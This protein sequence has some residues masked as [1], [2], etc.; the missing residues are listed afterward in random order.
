MMRLSGV[1][2]SL[3]IKQ[4]DAPDIVVVLFVKNRNMVPRKIKGKHTTKLETVMIKEAL[5]ALMISGIA[6]SK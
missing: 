6:C 3:Q 1:E 4:Q 5:I 2:D